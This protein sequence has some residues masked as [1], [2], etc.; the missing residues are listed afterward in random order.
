MNDNKT[1]TSAKNTNYIQQVE[2]CVA[3][4]QKK[5]PFIPP[6]VI[7]LGTGLG[8]LAGQVKPTLILPYRDI[9][10]FPVSTVNSHPGNLI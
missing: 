2:E 8:A 6:L 9:P 7:Q 3:F 1:E 5:L 4:L 10:N